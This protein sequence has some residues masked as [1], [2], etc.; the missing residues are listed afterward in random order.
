MICIGFHLWFSPNFVKSGNIG[1]T[2]SGFETG[3][4][5]LWLKKSAEESLFLSA[6]AEHTMD[7][8]ALNSTEY[9]YLQLHYKT[10]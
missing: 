7:N 4:Q 2:R 5:R 1:G 8:T 6:E 9:T 3:L 10:I